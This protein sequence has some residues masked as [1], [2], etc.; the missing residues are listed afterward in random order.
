MGSYRSAPPATPTSNAG[1]S[2]VGSASGSKS[3]EAK[4]F[5]NLIC[6]PENFL[7]LIQQLFDI[8]VKK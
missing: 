8:D 4:I 1:V 5:K 3:C 7:Y 6:D 2:V